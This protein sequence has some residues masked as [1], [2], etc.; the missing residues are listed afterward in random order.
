MAQSD[1]PPPVT[2]ARAAKNNARAQD[3]SMDA[4]LSSLD[5][6]GLDVND[7][8]WQEDAK[9]DAVWVLSGCVLWAAVVGVLIWL[10]GTLFYQLNP[11]AELVN[12]GA[13]LLLAGLTAL[14]WRGVY[15][16]VTAWPFGDALA[17]I[18]RR[19]TRMSNAAAWGQPSA[20]ILGLCIVALG[21]LLVLLLPRDVQ[22]QGQGYTGAWF[23]AT[24]AAIATGILVGRFIIAHASIERPARPPA[25]PIKWPSWTRWATGGSILALG[26]GVLIAHTVTVPGDTSHEFHLAGISLFVG[27]AAAIWLARRFDELEQKWQK[28]AQERHQDHQL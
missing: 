14:L 25:E 6:G 9:S 27:V 4:Y 26:A 12:L 22:W 1:L 10:P 16:L 18:K 17:A 3:P 28:E 24:L 2:S 19:Q 8:L 13:W 23:L 5:L 20:R 15:A 7:V 11:L 21:A